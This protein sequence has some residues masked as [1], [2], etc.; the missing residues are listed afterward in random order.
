MNVKFL[1]LTLIACMGFGNISAQKGDKEKRASP[2]AKMEYKVGDADIVIAYSQPSMKDRVIYGE[3][4]PYGKIW[5]TG[6]N[7]ATTFTTSKDVTINGKKLPAGTYS[8]FTIPGEDEWT[9][10]F[11]S[12][13]E[14]W[15]AY[16]YNEDKDVL[17][18]KAK[19]MKNKKTEQ[20][21]FTPGEG[22]VI[23][24]DWEETRV[25]FTV[26]A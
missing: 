24:L 19:P 14:Q 20:M 2:P 11:N 25:P 16:K 26:K 7:E 12:D 1:A 21:T 4:V 3:L 9:I 17:R 6:A 23:Y 5:R 15:G 10:I 18:V 22:G 8:L 13:A